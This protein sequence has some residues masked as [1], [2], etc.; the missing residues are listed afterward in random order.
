MDHLGPGGAGPG[1]QRP[2]GPGGYRP[3]SQDHLDLVDLWTELA[4]APA[5]S[6]WTWRIWTEGPS[7]LG[8]GDMV[9]KP[10]PSDLEDT[11]LEAKDHLDD[12]SD[13]TGPSDLRWTFTAAAAYKWTWIRTEAKDHLDQWTWRNWSC[14]GPSGPSG[15][16]GPELQAAAAQMDWDMD[17]QDHLDLD[18][19][20]MVPKPRYVWKVSKSK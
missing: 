20:D 17:N 9:P 10:G 14:Q 5:C 13:L 11:D 7:D 4:A 19:E 2:S 1:S 15:P 16:G 6:K 12:M 3:G 8:P 18:L